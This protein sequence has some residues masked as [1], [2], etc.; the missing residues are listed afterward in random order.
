MWPHSP[1]DGCATEYHYW[2]PAV[3]RLLQ[4]G[5]GWSPVGCTTGTGVGAHRN[6]TGKLNDTGESA[7]SEARRQPSRATEGEADADARDRNGEARMEKS[8]CAIL[9]GSSESLGG[10]T[11][12]RESG[13]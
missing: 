7:R 3:G 1:G 9:G 8:S 11:I 6:S 13:L 4:H 12:M 2:T 10:L 5:S